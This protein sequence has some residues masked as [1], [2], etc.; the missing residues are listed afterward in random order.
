GPYVASGLS[1]YGVS[2][3]SPYG[4]SGVSPYG[5]S[6]VSPYGVSGVSPYVVSGFSR[7]LPAR[8]RDPNDR[9]AAL[10]YLSITLSH[11]RWLVERWYV[12]YG[13]EATERWLAF[14]NAAAPLTLRANRLRNT[15]D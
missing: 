13:F 9:E 11:P 6:G 10:D 15:P 4:V 14:N 1:P 12:R 7:T 8:P 5:V 2:G 3:V